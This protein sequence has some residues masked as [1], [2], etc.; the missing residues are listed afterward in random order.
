LSTVLIGLLCEE[1]AQMTGTTVFTV[2]RLFTQWTES[3]I[4]RTERRAVL[5]ENLFELAELAEGKD[6]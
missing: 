5:I 3:G 1:L 6:S 4:I 2:S